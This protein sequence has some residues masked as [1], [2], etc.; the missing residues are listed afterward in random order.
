MKLS[1]FYWLKKCLF[2]ILTIPLI[3]N[4]QVKK[5]PQS[6]KI[7]FYYDSLQAIVKC[8]H[9]SILQG[10]AL[11]VEIFL[12]VDNLKLNPQIIVEGHKINFE[13]GMA[14]YKIVAMGEGHKEL[15]GEILVKAPNGTTY[16]YPFKQAYQVF[17][18]R[19]CINN[20]RM[21]ILYAG[22]ENPVS[23]FVPNYFSD[24]IIVKTTGLKSF[25]GSKNNYIAI[26]EDN[27]TGAT[28]LV[29]VKTP[30][31]SIKNMGEKYFQVLH[32][33]EP[34]LFLGSLKTGVITVSDILANNVVNAQLN[35][36]V[37]KSLEFEIA[38]YKITIVRKDNSIPN[39]F[40]E[41]SGKN[42]PD[43]AKS[44]ITSLKSGDMIIISDAEVIGTTG[45]I[46]INNGA[47]YT[48]E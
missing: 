44:Q 34:K 32:I 18:G 47:I 30:E 14:E 15:K 36:F 31:G 22:L 48:I 42:L 6:G 29:S 19:A 7:N 1:S 24:E 5:T 4:G 17:V 2:L 25:K 12:G 28:V 27:A 20:D 37:Y 23:V 11:N 39:F 3:L 35:D 13:N 26:P 8:E 41:V 21:N 45:P 40:S 10:T 43:D 46:H 9:P 38:K 16:K 33:P